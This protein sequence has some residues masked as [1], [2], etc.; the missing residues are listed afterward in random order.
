MGSFVGH[1]YIAQGGLSHVM[2]SDKSIFDIGM[3]YGAGIA[4]YR[5]V[6]GSYDYH[7]LG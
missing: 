1:W 2:S 6:F 5:V 4:V 3:I 7:A